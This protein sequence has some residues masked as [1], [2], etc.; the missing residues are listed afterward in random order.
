MGCNLKQ[1]LEKRNEQCPEE[2]RQAKSSQNVVEEI[3]TMLAISTLN[4]SH[5]S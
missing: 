5:L 2:E 1:K 3:P 4:V